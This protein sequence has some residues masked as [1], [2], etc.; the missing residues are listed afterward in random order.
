MALVPNPRFL[1]PEL[2]L[3]LT[4]YVT[5]AEN[6]HAS[7]GDAP[8]ALHVIRVV[9]DE[10]YRGSIK[11]IASENV[12]DE[13]LSLR[14]TADFGGNVDEI[15][16]SWWSREEDGRWKLYGPLPPGSSE[17]SWRAEGS[18][19][20][21]PAL[22]SLDLVGSNPLLLADNLFFVRY[23]HTNSPTDRK[24]SWSDWAGA[25]NSSP[26]TNSAGQPAFRPQLATGWVKRVFNRLTPYEA[27]FNDFRNNPS[28][29]TY[30]SLIQQ[31]GPPPRGSVALNSDK[32][33]IESAGLL[34]IY[35]TVIDRA[36][37]L[38]IDA[39]QPV[40]TPGIAAALMLGTTRI[41]QLYKLLGD[42]AVSDAFDPTIGFGTSSTEYGK[43][44]PTIF[45]FQ[46]QVGS[47]LEEE[48][49]LLRG[50]D[51]DRAWP[52]HNRLSWNFTRAEGEAA[53]AMNYGIRD[54]NNDGFIN[55][56][57]GQIQF[58]QGHGDAWGHYLSAI[59]P[60]YE[61]LGNPNFNWQTRAEWFNQSDV[62]LPVDYLDER[63]FA[64]LAG[65]RANAGAE[66]VGL[67]LRALYTED[68]WGQWQGYQDGDTNRAWG[69]MEWA[70]RA[71][72]AALLDWVVA[73]A[74]L[75]SVDTNHPTLGSVPETASGIQKLDRASVA[76]IGRISAALG[77]IQSTYD[78]ANGRL[79]PLG[80]DPDVV[81]FDLDPTFVDVGSTAQIGRPAVQGL[82]HFEQIYE[83][84]FAAVDNATAAFDYATEQ[85]NQLRRIGEDVESNRKQAI[86]QD[87]EFRNRLIEIFGTPYRG[88][89]GTGKPYPPGYE[90]PD[91]S[92]WMYVDV[93]GV[94]KDTVPA[95]STNYSIPVTSFKADLV[96]LN[97][98]FKNLAVEGYPRD[99][100]NR[101]VA[102]WDA[103]LQSWTSVQLTDN[104]V[105]E[106]NMPATARAY[107]F[108]APSTWE[109]RAAP[110]RLQ[111]LIS[112]M[113]QIEADLA[114]AVGDYDYLLNDIR[115]SF[116]ILSAKVDL[117]NSSN[118]QG[119][120][121]LKA[122][123]NFN[124]NIQSLQ[125]SAA[126]LGALAD[127]TKDISDG[128]VEAIPKVL[129]VSFDSTAPIRSGIKIAAVV[130]G[131][132]IMRSGVVAMERSA[133][134]FEYNKEENA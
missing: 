17:L 48:L 19:N 22:N 50:L 6:N 95:S 102:N 112:D 20:G 98:K 119:E 120:D 65:A 37:A 2:V 96:K 23:R 45:A 104:S 103:S 28:P 26:T 107:T 63:K 39:T 123:R 7:L 109:E 82:T 67:S 106:L 72:Q 42:E 68:P 29:A 53:Y 60:Y 44:A 84:A 115:R 64:E 74:L 5:L 128:I 30:A 18:T 3:P 66:I 58:P 55:E 4:N 1:D 122:L 36:K 14:H 32:N 117:A 111:S 77:S 75:P 114:Y 87:T 61:L 57:D 40:N 38:S 43:L 35:Q 110:G 62:V 113:V 92:L 8:V 21:S 73:N 134:E 108:Q 86:A 54:V 127:F 94:S 25:A 99:F 100:F 10:L 16:F 124:D 56:R 9:R 85:Q 129:G 51:E 59:R 93:Q 24:E 101:A 88:T 79:N 126:A 12:F 34:E 27:R 121:Q 116:A 83:R 78:T 31:A 13:K 71:G 118:Q 97:E 11:T 70:R 47:L 46:N 90:G 33:V 49:A 91:L 52:V 69:T 133:A 41:S 130:G 105:L 125:S 89:I 81:P 131:Y 15:A 76:G 132:G 80:L